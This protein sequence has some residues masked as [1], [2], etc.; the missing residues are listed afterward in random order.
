MLKAIQRFLIVSLLLVVVG[1]LG[2]QALL[3]Y[4]SRDEMPRGMVIANVDV[5][6]MTRADAGAALLQA[7][8]APIVIVHRQEQIPVNP[9]DVGFSIDI[10]TMLNEA[11]AIRDAKSFWEGYVEY[12]LNRPLEPK[13]VRLIAA[14]DREALAG[15]LQRIADYLDKPATAPQLL[16]GAGSY[17][18]G[19]P[20]YVTDVEASLPLAEMALYQPDPADR[21]VEL[22][23][24]DQA[25]IPFNIDVLAAELQAQN[26]RG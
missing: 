26:Q 18:E 2:Y 15:Q 10:D 3:Y 16:T 23:I 6:E 22:V 4:L 24:K 17:Q 12:L 11:E 7:Y 21:E 19:E 5:S 13:A 14:H 1:Y 9:L 8:T 25:A 20:G